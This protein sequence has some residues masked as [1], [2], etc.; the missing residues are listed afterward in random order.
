[1]EEREGVE[2][3]RRKKEKGGGGRTDK[4]REIGWKKLGTK[5]GRRRGW[6]ERGE[7]KESSR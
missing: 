4:R 5:G 1:M 6:G 7:R 3:G 2:R